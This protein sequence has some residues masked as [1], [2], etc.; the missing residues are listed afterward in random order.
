MEEGATRGLPRSIREGRRTGGDADA[1]RPGVGRPKDSIGC[2]EV[3]MDALLGYS[4]MVH[5]VDKRSV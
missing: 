5:I 1:P 3:S 2:G 4:Q